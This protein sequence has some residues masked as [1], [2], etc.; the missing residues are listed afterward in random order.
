MP[1]INTLFSENAVLEPLPPAIDKIYRYAAKGTLPGDAEFTELIGYFIAKKEAWFARNR[2]Y[3]DS[4]IGEQIFITPTDSKDFRNWT[5]HQLNALIGTL[6]RARD[7]LVQL[8]TNP[9]LAGERAFLSFVRDL[10]IESIHLLEAGEFIVKKNKINYAAGKS[11]IRGSIEV[12]SASL[13]LFHGIFNPK[14][15]GSVVYRPASISLIRQAI[16]LRFKNIF[17]I[18]EVYDATGKPVRVDA[19]DLFALAEE[20]ANDISLPVKLSLVKKIYAWSNEFIHTGVEPFVWQIEWAHFILG[21]LFAH[22]SAGGVSSVYGS[23]LVHEDM[24]QWLPERLQRVL[25]RKRVG[26]RSIVRRLFA[27]VRSRKMPPPSSVKIVSRTSNPEAII[28][29][30]RT[31]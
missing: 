23:V 5:K 22:G 26:N 31:W 17:N 20:S 15:I 8:Q 12:W 25:E 29:T 6:E 18:E 4:H 13:E 30:Q 9:N 19:P 14:S 24:Y 10:T 2:K 3:T 21:P 16:E 1:S 27:W 11:K 28:V 7:H